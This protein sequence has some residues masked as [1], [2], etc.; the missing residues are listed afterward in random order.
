VQGPEKNP[1]KGLG[2]TVKRFR[3]GLRNLKKRE[4]GII[5]PTKRAGIERTESAEL[6]E[7]APESF[8]WFDSPPEEGRGNSKVTRQEKAS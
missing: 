1:K 5:P 7:R 2:S 3:G 4:R 8:R 6:G